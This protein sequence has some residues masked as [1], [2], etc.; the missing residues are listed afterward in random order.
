MKNVKICRDCKFYFSDT[1]SGRDLCKLTADEVVSINRISGIK[2]YNIVHCADR[3]DITGK[4][5]PQGVHFVPKA[6][7]AA[8][9]FWKDWFKK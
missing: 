7:V 5:G 2:K 1:Y 6:S 3:R 4:C 9:S 8:K